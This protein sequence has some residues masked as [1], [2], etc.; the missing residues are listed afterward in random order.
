M[1]CFQHVQG[2]AKILQH[3][4]SPFRQCSTIFGRSLLE[5]YCSLEGHCCLYLG[6]RTPLPKEWRRENVRVRKELAELEYPN[7]TSDERKRRVIDDLY[8][9]IWEIV[10][11]LA[12]VLA[13]TPCLK[14]LTGDTKARTVAN[15]KNLL[16]YARKRIK[17]IMSIPLVVEMMQTVKLD[18]DYTPVRHRECCPPPPFTQYA[19]AFPAVGY[20]KIMCLSLPSYI[21]LYLYTPLR[22][23]GLRIDAFEEE[24]HSEP[25]EDRAYEICRV[26][27]AIEDTFGEDLSDLLPC[28]NHLAIVGFTCPE[29]L[30]LWLWHKLAHFEKVGN[31]SMEPLKKSLSVVWGMPELLTDGFEHWKWSPLENRKKSLILGD[32]NEATAFARV[33]PTSSE[34]RALSEE[35]EDPL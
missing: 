12:D 3:F 9:E 8:Q 25:L 20:L 26:Y 6:Y 32:I 23:A 17:E 34:D 15:L 27:A 4:S 30:R 21:R 10:P 5:W 33:S 11:H 2:A 14:D 31:L 7:L 24:Y 18:K 16:L 22:Q 35:L 28:S 1:K 29:E 13:T 19:L